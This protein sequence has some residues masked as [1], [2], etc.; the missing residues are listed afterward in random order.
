MRLNSNLTKIELG[1]EN[2]LARNSPEKSGVVFMKFWDQS[3]SAVNYRQNLELH[4]F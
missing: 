2:C 4:W 1:D 3:D